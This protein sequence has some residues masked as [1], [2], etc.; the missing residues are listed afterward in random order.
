MLGARRQQI[1]HRFITSLTL[2]LGAYPPY[3]TFLLL[4][5]YNISA[6]LPDDV[7][8]KQILRFGSD[9]SFFATALAF[10]TGWPGKSYVY[11]MNEPNPWEG[12]WKGEVS[13]VFDIALLFMNFEEKLGERQKRVGREFA[14][15]FVKFINGKSTLGLFVYGQEKARCYGGESAGEKGCVDVDGVAGEGSGRRKAIFELSALIGLDGLASAWGDFFT[16]KF[17]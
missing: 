7:A 13:H 4:Q 17:G 2:S 1:A 6:A 15:D 9:I 3:Y 11:H 5:T 14:R 12:E 10:S 8:L 16:A